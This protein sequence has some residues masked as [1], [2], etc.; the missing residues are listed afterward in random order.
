MFISKQ[1]KKGKN[2]A[3]KKWEID[4]TVSHNTPFGSKYEIAFWI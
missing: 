2:T 4:E 1:R 3:S